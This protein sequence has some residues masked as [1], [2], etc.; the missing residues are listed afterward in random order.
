MF[1]L[2]WMWEMTMAVFTYNVLADAAKE[3]VRYAVVHGPRAGGGLCSGPG[4]PACGAGC[5]PDTSAANV[6]SRV[7]TFAQV[8][9]HDISAM[10]VNVQYLLDDGTAA[11]VVAVNTRVRVAVSYTYVPYITLPWVAPTLNT[12]AEGRIVH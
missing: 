12:V 10:T 6:V 5:T 11:T 4:C 7:N 3:G 2:F 1:V 9:L 8:S